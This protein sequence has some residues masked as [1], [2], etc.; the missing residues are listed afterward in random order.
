MQAAAAGI[1][2]GTGGT[3]QMSTRLSRNQVK[4]NVCRPAG[5]PVMKWSNRFVFVVLKQTLNKMPWQMGR[6]GRRYSLPY[7]FC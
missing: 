6:D 2:V 5:S 1:P 4:E 3:C 7:F